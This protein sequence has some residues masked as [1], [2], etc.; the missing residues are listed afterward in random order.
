MKNNMGSYPESQWT[1]WAYNG[2]AGSYSGYAQPP[3]YAA[4]LPESMELYS[5]QQSHLVHH[6]QMS[7]TT[8]TKPRL[9][10]EEVEVL[11]AEFQ[12]NHKPNSSTKKALA[13]SM[14]VDHA[15]INN[16]FQNRRAREKKENNIREYAAKQKLEK[17][18]TV[19]ETGHYLD[20]DRYIDRV[21]SSAP[22]PDPRRPSI[23]SEYTDGSPSA[24]LATPE[25]DSETSQSDACSSPDMS[26]HATPDRALSFD[27]CNAGVEYFS[28][29]PEVIGSKSAFISDSTG[30]F[31]SLGEPNPQI[32]SAGLQYPDFDQFPQLIM[33]NDDCELTPSY[34]QQC[35][36]GSAGVSPASAQ[37]SYPQYSEQE[38]DENHAGANG[39][40]QRSLKSPPSMDI[41]SRR[42]RRPPHLAINASRSYSAGVPRTAVDMGRRTDV[43]SSMR[44]VAS[45][46]GTV[47]IS[48][49]SG[50]PRSPFF[51]RSHEVLIQ[52]NRPPSFS[53]A[54]P[55]IAPPTPNTPVVLNQQ[56]MCEVN[57]S[58]A[59]SL[60]EKGSL[61][62]AVH[63][64]TLRTPPTTP[65]IIEHMFTVNSAYDVPVSDEPLVTP[66]LGSFPSDFEVPGVSNQVPNYITNGCSSQ[67]QTPSY[68]PH[69]GPNYFGYS[70]G[71]AE[72]NW[73]DP[74]GSAKS[75][76]GQSHQ[77]VQFM[78]MTP[79]SFNHVEK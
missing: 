26:L 11:E 75:S 24:D 77:Q 29:K 4:Y 34:S 66:G 47:R 48:K 18:K 63:D 50:T 71:N 69:M 39:G 12:K 3:S 25:H 36:P 30:E 40:S 13:E 7:R 79:S 52:L 78:N 14:R 70:G 54:T 46:T 21:A 16:W 38:F 41:A 58:C 43:G 35:F 68:T 56:G 60:N 42:N 76:P 28:L 33:P 27:S 65:G 20:T 31:L 67:P 55:T 62:L 57:A 6:Q 32:P 51:D 17:D 73:S 8:E 15:R 44:R 37:G 1:G 59:L 72:Y 49:P 10:K 23:K 61:D 45:A 53:G 2:A 19:A 5:N 74:S 64:P 9:S 22:F